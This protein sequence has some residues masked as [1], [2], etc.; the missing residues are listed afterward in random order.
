MNEVTKKI[1]VITGGSH[2]LGRNTVLSLAK[3][4]VDSILPIIQTK[5]KLRK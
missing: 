4:G 1:A 3:R 5:Q 2:G